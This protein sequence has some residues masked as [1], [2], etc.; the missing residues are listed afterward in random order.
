MKRLNLAG[1]LFVVA[2]ACVAEGFVRLADAGDSVAAPSATV[3]ALEEGLR[4]GSLCRSCTRRSSSRGCS[5][6]R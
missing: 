4:S 5:A 2:I 3:R 1:W 6:M